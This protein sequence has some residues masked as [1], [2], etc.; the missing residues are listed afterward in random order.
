[1]G[2][3]TIYHIIAR[4]AFLISSYAIHVSMAYYLS[5]PRDYGT[6][7]VIISLITIAR[8]FLS[9]GM[10]QAT[11]K[12]IAQDE[13]HADVIL[14][15]ALRIQHICAAIVTAFYVGGIPV[16]TSL[17]NDKS[18]A[19]YIVLSALLIPLMGSLQIYLAYLNGKRLFGY[20]AF[21]IGLYSIGRFVIAFLLVLLGFKIFG[22]LLGF[23]FSTLIAL[24]SIRLYT[25]IRHD[26]YEFKGSSL[27]HF[28]IP[29]IPFSIGISLLLDM[30]IL[31]LKHFFSD[32][33]IIGYYT[34]AMNLGKAPYLIF[35]AFSMTILPSVAKALS[36]NDM[37]K[38]QGLIKRNLS[39]LFLLSIPSATMVLATSEKL[40]EF[41]YPS[42]YTEASGPLSI[43]IFSM[44]ALALFHS[45]ASII[46]AQGRPKTAMFIIILCIPTQIG[47]SLYLIPEYQMNGAAYSNLIT[48]C[49]GTIV[50]GI[51]V[52]KYF[53]VLFDI[54]R[55][56]KTI[57]SSLIIYLLLVNF[58][59]YPVQILP[60]IYGLSFL[61]FIVLMK[62]V[63]GITKDDMDS[64]KRLVF[65]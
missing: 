50:A 18:L 20:Q 65:K 24:I 58:D 11:S 25:K 30:D 3:G 23:I 54:D 39:Y 33:T 22:V 14:K 5:D 7:G 38:A 45:L 44:S 6:L 63:G 46:T 56:L 15:K 36:E 28:A 35:Y 52:F 17:L 34:G 4:L 43:L 32:S 13:E 26:D 42:V 40:L 1:M 37:K 8:V 49:L 9:T 57:F 10:P 41:V 51:F 27:I 47:L 60:L 55:V 53:R 48:V 64:L 21:F 19:K 2:K 59:T 61:A 16:W 62:I 31:L 12:F 29:I